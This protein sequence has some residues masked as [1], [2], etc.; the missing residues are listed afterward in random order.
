MKTETSLVVHGKSPHRWKKGETG[1][2]FGSPRK[3]EI[4]L[5][6]QAIAETE[7]EKKK[8]LWKLLIEKCYVDNAVLIAVA[9][10]FLPD[11]ISVDVELT[12]DDAKQVQA[13]VDV[14]LKEL[15]A[16]HK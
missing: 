13:L 4:E 8:S 16:R 15:S 10:K 5:V 14:R 2:P 9:K 6:R 3:P 12:E 7:R 1:N 11:K